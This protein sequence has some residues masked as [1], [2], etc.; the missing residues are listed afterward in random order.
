M[1]DWS[2]TALLIRESRGHWV[3]EAAAAVHAA[4]LRAVLLAPPM[5]AAEWAAMAEVVDDVVAVE[6]VHDAAALCTMIR[7]ITGGATPAGVLTGS[8]GAIA[9]TARVA[10]LLGVAH[11]PADAFVLAGNKFAVR[12]VLAEAGVPCPG[13]ALIADP[14]EAGVVAAEVGLPAIVKPVNG[15]GSN[16]VRTVHTVG[17]LVEAYRLLAERLPESLD[18]RYHRPVLG[19]PGAPAIDPA[20]V[21][22][23]EALLRGPEYAVDVLIRDGEVEP[24]EILDKPLIDEHKFELALSCPPAGLSEERAG[25]V[26]A[27]ASAA[28]RALGLDNTCAHVEVIDDE[29]S[30]PT[31]VEVNAGRP[32]G[33]IMPLLAK[34]RTGIDVIAESVTLALGIPAPPRENAKLPIPLGMLILY[35]PCGG[36]LAAIHGLDEVAALPEVINVITTVSPGEVLSDEQE[37]YGVNLVV[38]GFTDHDDLAALHAEA[39]KLIRF[40]MRDGI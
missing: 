22:L 10:E 29:V 38:A 33:S 13:F 18:D 14:A 19:R 7:G 5:D 28:V 6:D 36:R 12:Q 32:A 16:L 2:K 26:V 20:K 17:E 34:L 15:A 37:T 30:G 8:D 23:V 1:T 40:E 31:I 39:A 4:G 11:C 3:G 24:V 35:P 21:F 25:L 9:C 27:A